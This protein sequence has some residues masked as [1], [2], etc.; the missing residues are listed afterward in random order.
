MAHKSAITG[1]VSELTVD[2]ILLANRWQVAKPVV[3]ETY[4]RVLFD[5]L[6]NRLTAQIKTMKVRNDRGGSF[7]IPAVKGNGEPYQ[8]EDCDLMIGVL[9][10]TIYL[11]ETTGIYEYSSV[12]MNAKT[13]WVAMEMPKSPGEVLTH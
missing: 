7:V 3:D 8:P 4:D 6:G 5:P 13:R 11:T 12:E 9:G 2:R 10:D 1:E